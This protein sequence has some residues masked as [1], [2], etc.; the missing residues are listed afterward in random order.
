MYI[1]RTF[2]MTT[3]KQHDKVVHPLHYICAMLTNQIT[4]MIAVFGLSQI[5]NNNSHF[6]GILIV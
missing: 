5:V 1:T 2:L 3:I 4:T 6:T